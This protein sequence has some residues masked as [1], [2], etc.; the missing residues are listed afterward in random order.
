MAQSSQKIEAVETRSAN[1]VGSLNMIGLPV[2]MLLALI[3]T[4]M[5]YDVQ[6]TYFTNE[7]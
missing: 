4:E 1:R 7:V 2:G 5:L 6:D 3:I